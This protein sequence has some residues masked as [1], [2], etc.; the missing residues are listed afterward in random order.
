MSSVQQMSQ[1]I[2]VFMAW[3]YNEMFRKQIQHKKTKICGKKNND[4]SKMNK[5]ILKTV[6]S[7][8]LSEV[9]NAIFGCPKRQKY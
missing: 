9:L 7:L 8:V 6:K 1:K 5:D 2:G 4:I 3:D